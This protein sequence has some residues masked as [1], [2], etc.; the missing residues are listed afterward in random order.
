MHTNIS[1]CA[2]GLGVGVEVRGRGRDGRYLGIGELNF[3]VFAFDAGELA[4]ECERMF[5][6]LDIEARSKGLKISILREIVEVVEEA[7]ERVE[8]GC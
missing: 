5:M 3:H 1:T 2:T 7:E 6:F 8:T 4:V